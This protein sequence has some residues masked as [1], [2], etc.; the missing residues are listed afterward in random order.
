MGN[1]R[2]RCH[3]QPGFE[4]RLAEKYTQLSARLQEAGDHLAANPLDAATRSLRAVAD[5]SGMA[6]AT[7]SRLARALD[8]ES[9]EQLRE[10]LRAELGRRVSSFASRAEGL[11]RTR[12]EG[13]HAFLERSL[14]AVEGNLALLSASI[15]PAQLDHT[16]ETLSA[17]RKVLIMG[18]LGSTGIAEYAGYM[19]KFLGDNWELTGRMGASLGS[20]FSD[21]APGDGLV[22][23]TKPPY[24]TL[25]L[26]AAEAARARGAFV[27]VIT[28]S[29]ACPALRNADSGF[30]VPSES[31]NFFS[32][33]VATVFLLE[34]IMAMVAKLSGPETSMRISEIERQ[35]RALGEVLDR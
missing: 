14:T 4:M 7:F 30:I 29:H 10:A 20:A 9:F 22:V 21:L 3:L 5:D 35:N 26:R 34:T 32:S 33:Y 28:D 13:V 27:V 18:A 1:V 24:A 8:Y 6:P 31:P 15:D 23:V 25:S 12:D 19:G 11:R 16:V 17:A 2:G